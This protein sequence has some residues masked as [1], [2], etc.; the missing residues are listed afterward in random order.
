RI[1]SVEPSDYIP[2]EC[3]QL[4]GR[5]YVEALRAPARSAAETTADQL[6]VRWMILAERL[7]TLAE[8]YDA[9]DQLCTPRRRRFGAEDLASLH[10][11]VIELGQLY[12]REEPPAHDARFLDNDASFHVPAI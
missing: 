10:A 2:S 6:D 9:L 4:L 5:D 12:Q 11:R 7:A 8:V 3:P 1:G